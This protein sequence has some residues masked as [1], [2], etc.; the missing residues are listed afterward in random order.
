MCDYGQRKET[1][2]SLNLGTEEELDIQEWQV[3]LDDVR[4]FRPTIAITG[5]EPLLY[6]NLIEF[7]RQC[8]E[9]KLNIEITTN[10]YLLSDYAK[11]FLNLQVN[12]IFVSID[13]PEPVHNK[14]RG[15]KD[16]FTKAKNGIQKILELKQGNRPSIGINYT[17]SNLNYYSLEDTL[18][19]LEGMYDTFLFSHLNFVSK[20]MAGVHNQSWR[21]ICLATPSAISDEIDRK[22]VDINV[23]YA[24]IERIKKNFS[25]ACFNPDLNRNQLTRY[26]KE[27]LLF[28]N[29]FD[30]CY[31]P[32]KVS[33]VLANGDVVVSTRCFRIIFG[34][35]RKQKFKEIW[36]SKTFE[37]F[38][39][40]LKDVG[41]F[42]ACTRCCGIFSPL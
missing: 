16:A 14:I 20:E 13:G 40:N 5:T 1:N 28:I 29:G 11:D 32:W 2:F 15:V 23:L 18:Q 22:E 34:N 36:D 10:G 33:Q 35:V 31:V 19:V 41:A 21:N 4:S 37:K 25:K 3:F 7:I 30:K 9:N 42:P 39:K 26:Y 24:Q 8:K 27:P 6:P 12:K 38:R 17:I